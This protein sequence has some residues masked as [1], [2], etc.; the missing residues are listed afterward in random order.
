MQC[1]LHED[2]GSVSGL[3]QWVKDLALLQPVV[4][5]VDAALISVAV[6]VAAAL[7]PVR[8]LPWELPYASGAAIKKKKKKQYMT[9][10]QIYQI[11][12]SDYCPEVIS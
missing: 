6:A 2:V 3:T 10:G 8:P 7:A 9:S 4:Q 11:V 12:N 1:C 5:V